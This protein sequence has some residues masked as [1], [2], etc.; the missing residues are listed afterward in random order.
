MHISPEPLPQPSCHDWLDGELFCFGAPSVPLVFDNPRAVYQNRYFLSIFRGQAAHGSSGD[1][2]N[3]ETKL[4]SCWNHAR[5]QSVPFMC[6]WALLI[7]GIFLKVKSCFSWTRHQTHK[8]SHKGPCDELATHPRVDLAFAH[9]WTP[10]GIKQSRRQSRKTVFC[11]LCV[12]IDQMTRWQTHLICI[13]IN[14]GNIPQN[15]IP[16]RSIVK[17]CKPRVWIVIGN[18]SATPSQLVVSEY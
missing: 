6:V 14:C 10:K 9:M 2:N 7:F 8:C 1:A 5:L 13:P 16:V 12:Q 4:K 17:H 3:F 11:D 15:L 18:L